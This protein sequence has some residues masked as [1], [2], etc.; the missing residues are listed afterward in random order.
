VATRFASLRFFIVGC[1]LLQCSTGS[2]AT[3]CVLPSKRAAVSAVCGQVINT[4]G[5]PLNGVEL[6]LTRDTD[7]AT[8]TA[9]SDAAGRFS[10]RSVPKGDYTLRVAAPNYRGA[11]RQIR[12]TRGSNKPCTGRITV[13][14]GFDVCDTGVRVKGTDK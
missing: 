13:T 9:K 5:E 3:T 6:S 2:L 7:A 1:A 14:L 4:A 10:F 8:F 11:M 12:V